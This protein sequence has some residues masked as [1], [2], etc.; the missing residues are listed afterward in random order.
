[1][2]KNGRCEGLRHG[3]DAIA[4]ADISGI[5]VSS[6]KVGMIQLLSAGREKI[7]S[8]NRRLNREASVNPRT[9]HMA[10]KKLQ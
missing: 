1:M 2:C 6:R 10:N 4:F 5:E 8:S 7:M 3:L 9:T